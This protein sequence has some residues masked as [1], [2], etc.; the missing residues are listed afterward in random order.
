LSSL[1][2]SLEA[3]LRYAGI[4]QARVDAELI[5]GHVLGLKRSGLHMEGASEVS[6]EDEA[7]MIALARRRAE[8]YPLQYITGECEFHSLDFAV[9]HGVFIPRP[10]TEVLVDCVAGMAR[11]IGRAPL[12]LLEIGAG[13]GIVSVSLALEL[14]GGVDILVTDISLEAVTLTRENAARH[15][16][17]NMMRFAVG[18]G[19]SFLKAAAGGGFDI[20]VSNPPYV[21]A[22]EIE[23]LEPEVRDYE[24]RSALDGGED[25]LEFVRRIVPGLPSIMSERALV[26]FEIAPGQAAS[27]RELLAGA[28][29]SETETVKDLAGRDRVVT[30]RMA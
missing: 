13:T 28:G 4:E 29:A 2:A 17:E 3:L 20:C 15:G 12:K 24:P 6:P 10:E 11:D 19:I 23:G 14:G 21:A 8:R 9:R 25:G 27:V 26:A 16:V 22:S 7:R 18:D 30:A 1:I 5:A